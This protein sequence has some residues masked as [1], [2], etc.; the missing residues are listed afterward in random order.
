MLYALISIGV[1]ALRAA[2]Y[3][4]YRWRRSRRGERESGR[5]PDE[6]GAVW[7]SPTSRL[8]TPRD[9]SAGDDSTGDAKERLLRDRR[10][11]YEAGLA[12]A[13]DELTVHQRALQKNE[14]AKESAREQLGKLGKKLLREVRVEL[15]R[16]AAKDRQAI[17]NAMLL[18][19]LY[20]LFKRLPVGW[21]FVVLSPVVWFAYVTYRDWYDGAW[22]GLLILVLFVFAMLVP[23]LFV[24]ERRQ[25][26]SPV[27]KAIKDEASNFENLRFFY[28]Y[29]YEPPPGDVDQLHVPI[30]KI[31]T[32]GTSGDETRT[33][34]RTT[35]TESRLGDGGGFLSIVHDSTAILTYRVS[36]HGSIGPGDAATPFA[37]THRK[38]VGYALKRRSAELL[39]IRK[40]IHRYATLQEDTDRL[41]GEVARLESLL[42]RVRRLESIWEE[43]YADPKV[44]DSVLRRVDLFN[45][46]SNAAPPGILL[47]GPTGN[48]KEFLA[49]KIAES[50]F[51]RFIEVSVAETQSAEDVKK[52]WGEATS[53]GPA[54]LYVEYAERLFPAP[55]STESTRLPVRSDRCLDRG[56]GRAPACREPR[57]GRHVFCERGRASPARA[58]ALQ[59]LSDRNSRAGPRR[60]RAHSGGRVRQE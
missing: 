31:D 24:I 13:T 32:K 22:I 1:V 49:R 55:E 58:P 52:I 27:L 47:V 33:M 5:G 29:P 45:V 57:V 35:W 9:P 37:K 30:L 41:R 12:D 23:I 8:P 18:R 50:V 44:L 36:E 60:A 46:R 16:R 34:S 43:V 21:K 7:T 10:R 19:P 2:L 17:I 15:R 25:L 42:S 54:V 6:L 51:A 56:V 20:R 14:W 4:L 11:K 3:F 59:Q 38:L 39:G 28:V 40:L 26:L 48:G 53:G